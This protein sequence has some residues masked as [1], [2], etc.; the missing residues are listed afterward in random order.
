MGGTDISNMR[1]QGETRFLACAQCLRD[2]FTEDGECHALNKG[3]E[4]NTT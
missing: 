1:G 3:V 2:S 4:R